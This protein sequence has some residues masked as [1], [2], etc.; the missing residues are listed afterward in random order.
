MKPVRHYK[1]VYI[2]NFEGIREYRKL[3]LE[4]WELVSMGYN[5]VLL[6]KNDWQYAMKAEKRY[7]AQFL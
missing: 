7:Q 3:E 6:L 5:T 4:G 1:K 2:G